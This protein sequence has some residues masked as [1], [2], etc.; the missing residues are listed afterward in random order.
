[1][2][3]R[4]I[5]LSRHRVQVQR[6][7][8]GR[9]FKRFIVISITPR[10]VFELLHKALTHVRNAI[11]TIIYRSGHIVAILASYSYCSKL[12]DQRYC[13]H[14]L[15]LFR[16]FLSAFNFSYPQILFVSQNTLLVQVKGTLKQDILFFISSTLELHQKS[17]A[18][19]DT[20]LQQKSY[21]YNF[22]Y[23]ITLQHGEEKLS[24]L[25][26]TASSSLEPLSQ[27][28]FI[29]LSKSEPI[30]LLKVIAVRK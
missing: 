5:S 9:H 21:V 17:S 12:I 4:E 26:V 27:P 2:I 24:L 22:R 19:S 18:L 13:F 28:K 8:I 6:I 10:Y 30:S 7:H 11:A 29:T 20:T 25:K 3:D 23:R 16:Y 14:S 1:M 15:L